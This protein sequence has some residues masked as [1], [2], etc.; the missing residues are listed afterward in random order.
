[1]S[2]LVQREN[3]PPGPIQ[4]INHDDRN[5]TGNRES[6]HLIGGHIA[7]AQHKDAQSLNCPHPTR[8]H[9]LWPAPGKLPLKADTQGRSTLLIDLVTDGGR[10]G[11]GGKC[12][13]KLV[14]VIPVFSAISAIVSPSSRSRLA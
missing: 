11:R 1:V 6:P 2:E 5:I 12:R 14:L 4:R 8:K 3:L 13:Y 10:G 9:I 7:G